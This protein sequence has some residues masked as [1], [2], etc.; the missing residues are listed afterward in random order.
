[1]NMNTKAISE[2]VKTNSSCTFAI[3]NKTDKTKMCASFY[4]V[5]YPITTDARHRHLISRI[6]MA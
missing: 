6:L 4:S 5:L 1:M 2:I 3:P